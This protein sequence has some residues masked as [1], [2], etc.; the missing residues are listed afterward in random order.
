KLVDFGTFSVAESAARQGRN[1]RT[2]ERTGPGGRRHP[3]AGG[4]DPGVG[5]HRLL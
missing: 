5:V 2:G 3:P 1:P 4:P